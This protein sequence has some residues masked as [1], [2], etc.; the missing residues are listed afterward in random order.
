M[1]YISL[2]LALSLYGWAVYKLLSI[3]FKWFKFKTSGIRT[4][5]SKTTFKR[6]GGAIGLGTAIIILRVVLY[7]VPTPDPAA[8]APVIATL[9]M[10]SP[11]QPTASAFVN[12]QAILVREQE[13]YRM[14]DEDTSIKPA[15]KPLFKLAAS[16]ALHDE[17]KCQSVFTAGNSSDRPGYFVHCTSQN[18][19]GFNIY[20][21]KA[22]IE[23][24]QSITAAQSYPKEQAITACQDAL[25]ERASHKSTFKPSWFPPNV[26]AKPDGV[27]S[28]VMDFA[29]KN[30]YGLELS[31]YGYC[32]VQPDGSVTVESLKER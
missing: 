10:P 17:P 13:A 28:V 5:K 7:P 24:G 26:E 18:E 20:F 29:I 2:L 27:T 6:V 1:Y 9:D 21:T 19:P 4:P 14:I 12:T 3:A 16:R 32:L 11:S 8:S 15:D 23:Q 30:S 25:K 31:M 22:E